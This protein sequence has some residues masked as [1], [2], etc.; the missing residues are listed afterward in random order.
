MAM[1]A[2]SCASRRASPRPMPLLP[3]V[4]SATRLRSDILLPGK[5][6]WKDFQYSVG[7]AEVLPKPGDDHRHVIGLLG[8]P[9]PLLGGGHQRLSDHEGCGALHVDGGFLQTANPKFFAIDVL[10]LD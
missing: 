7:A 8:S 5:I 3:P 6:T 1:R 4:T 2:P 9:S 10:R